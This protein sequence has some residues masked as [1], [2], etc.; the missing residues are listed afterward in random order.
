MSVRFCQS[1]STDFPF[2]VVCFYDN[3]ETHPCG[4]TILALAE[5]YFLELSVFFRDEKI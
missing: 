2:V 5:L 1:H 4:H 3:H